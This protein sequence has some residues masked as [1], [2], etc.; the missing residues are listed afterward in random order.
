MGM[1]TGHI[2]QSQWMEQFGV[3]V[4]HRSQLT[5]YWMGQQ[6]A[7]ER[8]KAGI[9]W[10]ESVAKEVQYDGEGLTPGLDGTLARQVRVYLATK[11]LCRE[12]GINFLGLTGQLDFTEWD[13]GCIMDIAEALLND[14][15]DWEDEKKDPII[16]ATEC[17]SNAALTMQLMHE[18]TGTPVLFA[19]LRHYHADLDVYDLVN[20]GQH[21][22]WLCHRSDDYR[23]NWKDIRLMPASP[24]YFRGGGASVQFY[25]DAEPVVTYARITRKASLYRCHIFT[26]S[27][28]DYGYEKNEELGNMTNYTWPHVWAKFDMPMKVLADNFSANH[29]HSVPGNIVGEMVAACEALGIEATVLS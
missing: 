15:A 11:D 28:V 21:A 7:Q 16:C 12:Q 19:D 18:I 4:Y 25:A 14:T 3:Q 5:L 6:I 20:S 29:L 9:E 17:D 27:W 23:E 24:F 26:G 1:Y 13:Q 2:D 10:L 8:V 22:P